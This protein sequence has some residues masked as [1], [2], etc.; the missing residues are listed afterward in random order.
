METIRRDRPDRGHRE[1][2]RLAGASQNASNLA[3]RRL[4]D[5]GLVHVQEA[6]RGAAL[7]YTPTV[8]TSLRKLC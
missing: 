1:V 7:L 5:H 2:A 3:L 4:V 6:G 8:I